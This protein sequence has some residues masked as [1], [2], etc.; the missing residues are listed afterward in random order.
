MKLTRRAGGDPAG[1]VTTEV[2]IVRGGTSSRERDAVAAEEP[3]QIRVVHGPAGARAE[4]DLAVT[5]R[6][7]GDD[8]ALALG[9]L[10]GEGVVHAAD[11]VAAVREG[12][13]T[14]SVELAP[15]VAYDAERLRRNV[16]T[17]SSCGICGV[18]SIEAVQVHIPDIAGQDAFSLEPTVLGTLPARLRAEQ[19]A[20]EETGGL[21][22]SGAFDA[23]GQVVVAAEDVGRHNALDKLV[24]HLMAEDRLPMTAL[25]LIFSGRAS[26]ELVQKAA[27]AGCPFIAAIGPPSSLAVVLAAEQ[28]MTL[29]GFLREDRF[30]VY[31]LPHRVRTA[32]GDR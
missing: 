15:S 10:H 31:T 30:N 16:Y 6:T 18:A 23:G 11:D 3:L 2:D 25:G 27:M 24:G 7:P 8:T 22:A 4:T 5:M 14:V 21:H 32:A 13:N 1:V 17:S 9:F 19:A 26:F 20:F 28:R 12:E 29:V